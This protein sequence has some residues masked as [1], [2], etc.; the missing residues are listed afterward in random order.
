MPLKGFLHMTESGSPIAV[1]N[2]KIVPISRAFGV[3][4]PGVVG[5]FVWNRPLAVRIERDGES[6]QMIPINDLTRI[7]QVRLIVGSVIATAVIWAILHLFGKKV[8]KQESFN[9]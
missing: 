3:T 8:Q 4:L 1:G 9:G 2:Y 6:D 7:A 5:G